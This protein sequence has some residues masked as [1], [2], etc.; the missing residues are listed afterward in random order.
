MKSIK[1][2]MKDDDMTYKEAVEAYTDDIDR[3]YDEEK[4]KRFEGTK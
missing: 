2:Y 3:A 1:R 4:D